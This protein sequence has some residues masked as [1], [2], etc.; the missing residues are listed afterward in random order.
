M[1]AI[2][3]GLTCSASNMWHGMAGEGDAGVLVCAAAVLAAGGRCAGAPV[4]DAIHGRL[5][6]V[7][8]AAAAHARSAL[9]RGHL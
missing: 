3:L 2:G 8:G 6:R 1:S 9:L 7:L 5:P 4:R